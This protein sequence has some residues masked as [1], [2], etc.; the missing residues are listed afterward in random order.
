M[1]DTHWGIEVLPVQSTGGT[2]LLVFHAHL[3]PPS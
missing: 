1:D 3:D 2:A